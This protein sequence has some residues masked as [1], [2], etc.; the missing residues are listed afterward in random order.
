M[1]SSGVGIGGIALLLR[2]SH[3]LHAKYTISPP[4]IITANIKRTACN[5][6]FTVL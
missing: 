3:A 4:G 1:A 6:G 2:H 5:V